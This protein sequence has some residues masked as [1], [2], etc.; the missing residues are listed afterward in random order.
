MKNQILSMPDDYHKTIFWKAPNPIGI[1]KADDGTYIDVNEAFTKL[2]GVRKQ[3][4]IGKSSIELGFLTKEKRLEL[5]NQIEEKG[6]AENVLVKHRPK[7]NGL[8]CILLNTTLIKMKNQ[9][10]WHTVGTN[11]SKAKLNLETRREEVFF[12]LLDSF[13]TMGVVIYNHLENKKLYLFYVN[14][15]A[16]KILE[17]EKISDLIGALDTNGSVFLKYKTTY[18]HVRKLSTTR[19]APMKIIMMEKFPNV[20]PANGEMKQQALTPRQQ[21]I[22]FLVATGH[23]NDEIAEKLQ[24]TRHTVKDHLKKV[25][26]IYDVHNRV[27][28]GPKILSWR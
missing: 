26:Q 18:Y 1:S 4:I 6:H 19:N 7:G 22:A 17:K 8:Q 23:S 13:D 2:F 11:I 15:L 10:F 21:E 12:K 25:F 24:I 5:I 20:M 14:E 3:E 16:K 27:E 28:L 9:S